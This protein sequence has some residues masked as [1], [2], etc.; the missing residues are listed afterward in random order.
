MN[1]GLNTL[2]HFMYENEHKISITI[3]AYLVDCPAP[4]CRRWRSSRGRW[5]W[6]SSS[7]SAGS[8]WRI[9]C[10]RQLVRSSGNCSMQSALLRAELQLVLGSLAWCVRGCRAHHATNILRRRKWAGTLVSIC[11][12][13][14]NNTQPPT[15]NWCISLPC[16]MSAIP[17][18]VCPN[19]WLNIN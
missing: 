18:Q 11:H 9:P 2:Q 3:A 10:L 13:Y 4:W 7:A 15:Q 16:P 1:R 6:C 12:L 17:W 5:S 19:L 14:L 8:A